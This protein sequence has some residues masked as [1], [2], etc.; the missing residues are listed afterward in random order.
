MQKTTTITMNEAE[1]RAACEALSRFEQT[2]LRLAARANRLSFTFAEAGETEEAEACR[3]ACDA[4][5][6]QRIAALTLRTR[7]EAVTEP[8]RA[9]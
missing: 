3:A 1:A 7:I 8:E 2:R 5:H 9:A 6:A 4:H